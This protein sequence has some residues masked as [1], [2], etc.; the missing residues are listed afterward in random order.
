[1]L[2]DRLTTNVKNSQPGFIN[3]VPLP[4]FVSLAHVIPQV[5]EVVSAMK[6]NKEEWKNYLETEDNKKLYEDKKIVTIQEVD[7]DEE[8]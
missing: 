6:T 1:M 3:F 4:L 8:S 7:I 5:S 2:C